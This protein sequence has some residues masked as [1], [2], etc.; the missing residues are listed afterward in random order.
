MDYCSEC[1]KC[2]YDKRAGTYRCKEKKHRILMP[3]R[4]IACEKF[5]FDEKIKLLEEKENELS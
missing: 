4:Y 2:V 3:E 5:E 1:V